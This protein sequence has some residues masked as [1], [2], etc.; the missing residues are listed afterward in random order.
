[1]LEARDRV[2]IRT[3]NHCLG[4]EFVDAVVEVGGQWI[5]LGNGRIRALIDELG[6]TTFDTY[7]QGAKLWEHNGRT[8]RYNGE[9][10]MAGPLELVDLQITLTRPERMARRIDPAAPWSATRAPRSAGACAQEINHLAGFR[11]QLYDRFGDG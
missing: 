10:P 1:M 2:G 3:L 8:R 5:G 6:L 4:S 7:D 9:V 11:P